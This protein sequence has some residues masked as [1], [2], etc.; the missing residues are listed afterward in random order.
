[1][2]IS[3]TLMALGMAFK[4]ALLCC[5]VWIKLMCLVWLN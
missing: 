2:H 1:M 4:G 3:F 5:K